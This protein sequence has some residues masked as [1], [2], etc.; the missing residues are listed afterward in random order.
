[1]ASLIIRLAIT[2]D[3]LYLKM[4]IYVHPPAPDLF[5]NSYFELHFL[6]MLIPRISKGILSDQ[7]ISLMVISSCGALFYRSLVLV[8][9]G[10]GRFLGTILI[11]ENMWGS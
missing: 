5:P 11:G 9:R 4:C 8:G 10:G 3:D 1:M 7:Q 2:E 6:M